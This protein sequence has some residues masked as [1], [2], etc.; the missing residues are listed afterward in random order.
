MSLDSPGLVSAAHAAARQATI[1]RALERNARRDGKRRAVI[2][3]V[4]GR[5]RALSYREFDERANRLAHAF[6]DM[7]VGAGDVVAMMDRNTAEYATVYFAT[8]KT[9]AAFTGVNPSFT[10]REL[11]YQLTHAAP[12]VVVAGEAYRQHVAELVESSPETAVVATTGLEELA[13]GKS[14]E[15]P[16][17]QIDESD[18]AM[19]VYTSGT[20]SFPKGVVVPHRNFQIATTPSWTSD[21][22][23]LASDVFLLLAPMY[24]MA[25]LGTLTNLLSIGA[26]VVITA[27]VN[28]GVVLPVIAAERVTNMS[29][30][31]TFYHRMTRLADFA[32]A[33]LSSLQQCH[34]YGGPIPASVVKAFEEKNPDILWASYWGQTELSQL[35]IVGFYRNLHEIP[36]RDLRWI[37]KPMAAVEVRV[38]DDDGHDTEVGE[39]ICRSPAIMDGYYKA[40]DLTAEAIRDGWLHTGD[41]V[42]IDEDSNIFFYDR[43]KDMIKTGGMNVSSLEVESIIRLHDSVHDVAVVGAPDPEWSE[44][45]TAFVV[46]EDGAELD[47]AGVLGTCREHLAPYK[48]PKAVHAISELPHDRQG[49][50]VKRELRALAAK[51][52][53]EQV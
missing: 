11:E 7:G 13:S 35:G 4:D 12:R 33:D 28:P 22:Y 23:I 21:G 25:G 10:D 38:V 52:T 15:D 51:R 19:I 9:G 2:D 31:P 48:I 24:T 49:K 46:L 41:I 27:S 50:V 18:T 34:S 40:P 17:R 29:Q 5:R 37:G 39:M 32:E 53:Q 6:I 14:G 36:N 45:V 3:I 26:T 43:K 1:G 47:V 30:T 44:A 8:L 16:G 20:E 42:R